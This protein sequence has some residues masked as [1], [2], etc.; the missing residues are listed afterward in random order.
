MY[1]RLIVDRAVQNTNQSS[2][3]SPTPIITLTTYTTQH[4]NKTTQSFISPSSCLSP[5]GPSKRHEFS[6]PNNHRYTTC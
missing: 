4:Y 6:K 5:D 1:T 3:Y 2:D